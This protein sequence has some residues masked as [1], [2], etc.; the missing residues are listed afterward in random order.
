MAQCK[1]IGRD[2]L[3]LRK[4][5][6][7]IFDFFKNQE[8]CPFLAFFVEKSTF[9]AHLSPLITLCF[10]ELGSILRYLEQGVDSCLKCW[11]GHEKAR[12]ENARTH[13]SKIS[14]LNARN[15]GFFRAF[16]CPILR[17]DRIWL[18]RGAKFKGKIL[19]DL[20]FYDQNSIKNW[21]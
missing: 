3:T 11:K 7:V 19:K 21:L 15:G 8:N 16:S 13:E 10:W 14:C 12:H 6:K 18:V 9:W 2:K 20:K 4:N 5:K 1:F 17:I